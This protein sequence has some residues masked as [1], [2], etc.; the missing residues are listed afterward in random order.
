M[1]LGTVENCRPLTVPRLK[2]WRAGCFCRSGLLTAD[3]DIGSPAQAGSASYSNGSYTIVAG[4]S[5]VGGNSDQFNFAYETYSG[6]VTLVTQV[7]SLPNTGTPAQAGLMIRNDTTAV[8]ALA[9]VFVTPTSG[10]E[11][12]TRTADGGTAGQTTVGGLQLPEYLE[13][14]L[15]GS[16][17]TAYYSSN[18]ISWTQIGTSPPITLRRQPPGRIGGRLRQ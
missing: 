6:N 16:T 18:G 4:G 1:C 3:Q 11:F 10:I 2:P 8:S 14:T 15:S 7:N 12:V 9:A 13:L 17:V 5:G